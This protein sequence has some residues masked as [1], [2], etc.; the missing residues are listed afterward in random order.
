MATITI[1]KEKAIKRLSDKI[2]EAEEIT[3]QLKP[4]VS[5]SEYSRLLD[6][7]N[8]WIDS[9]ADTLKQIFSDNHLSDK[10]SDDDDDSIE[11]E[12]LS[13]KIKNLKNE[14]KDKIKRLEHIVDDLRDNIY[15]QQTD[16]QASLAKW[17]F[18]QTI[19][20]ALITAIAGIIT[21][22]IAIPHKISPLDK[23]GL[24]TLTLEGKW[25]YICTSFDGTYQ[26]GGRLVVQKEKD[27]SLVLNGERMWRDT[28]DTLTQKWTCK[29]FEESDYLFWNT[30]W[31][32]V[33]NDTQINFE[34]KIPMKDRD[35]IGYCSGI[36]DSDDG[37]VVCIK[38][39]FYVI[40]QSPILTGQIIFKRVTDDD[41]GSKSTLTK[42]H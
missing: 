2:N 31:I 36:I 18:W 16:S 24:S 12:P 7:G 4:N 5:I 34:Y 20:V 40:N 25:K 42:N 15:K 1:S 21:G 19:I 33:R 23:Q 37:K 10:F 22:Y 32:L 35:V 38:G 3:L 14:L 11:S 27:G 6:E 39:N 29:N 30:N 26:H 8:I 28:K 41:Y 9:T 13:A 17:G